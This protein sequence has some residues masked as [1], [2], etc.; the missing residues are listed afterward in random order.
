VA[1]HT[2]DGVR[3]CA[4]RAHEGGAMA[5]CALPDTAGHRASGAEPGEACMLMTGGQDCSA[6][7]WSASEDAATLMLRYGGAACMR[8]RMASE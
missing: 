2:L 5:I 1:V 4:A 8:E 3:L 7:L 6:K